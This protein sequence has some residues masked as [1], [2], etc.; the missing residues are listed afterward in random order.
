MHLSKLILLDSLL[1]E[2]EDFAPTLCFR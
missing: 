1:Q 2:V